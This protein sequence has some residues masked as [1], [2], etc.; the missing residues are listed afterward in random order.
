MI[1]MVICDTVTTIMTAS[2]KGRRDVEQWVTSVLLR[3]TVDLGA[4]E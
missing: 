3:K 4:L 1:G 2:E